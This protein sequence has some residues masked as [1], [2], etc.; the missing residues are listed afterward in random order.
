MNGREW[1]DFKLATRLDRREH[2]SYEKLKEHLEK[3]GKVPR[4]K[5]T[6][7]SIVGKRASKRERAP[8]Y[9]VEVEDVVNTDD[10]QNQSHQAGAKE[11][12]DDA[13]NNQRS[14][15]RSRSNEIAAA[16]A[17]SHSSLP[18]ATKTREASARSSRRSSAER[19]PDISRSRNRSPTKSKKEIMPRPPEYGIWEDKVE[20]VKFIWPAVP[21]GDKG[22]LYARIF[23]YA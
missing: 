13:P 21:A 3:F 19:V 6:P 7:P 1:F 23:W 11:A 22:I 18:S 15:K 20:Y 5:E 8:S 4:R 14:N 9:F 16:A 2:F 10:T 17:S 12:Q